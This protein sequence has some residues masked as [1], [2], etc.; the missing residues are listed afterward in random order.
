MAFSFC[1][2]QPVFATDKSLS[3]SE[4]KSPLPTKALAQGAN[5]EPT[6]KLVSNAVIGSSPELTQ[7]FLE[8]LAGLTEVKGKLVHPTQLSDLELSESQP[9]DLPAAKQSDKNLKDLQGKQKKE[10]S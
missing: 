1:V 2:A 6:S 5:Q 9:T 7:D 4:E 8:Y 10:D 3:D